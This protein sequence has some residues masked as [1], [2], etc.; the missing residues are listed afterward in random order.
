M[1]PI[2]QLLTYTR[3]L[4][5]LFVIIAGCSIIGAL[6]SF[7]TPF[8]MKLATDWT[9]QVVSGAVPFSAT[10]LLM[11]GG[12]LLAATLLMT[13][14][15]DIN[16]YFG[17]M[18]A[19]RSRQQLSRIYYQHLLTLPQRYYDTASTGKVINRLSRAIADVT[20]FLQFF[21]NNLLQMI[22]TLILTIVIL[23]LYSWP[24]AILF[25]LLIPTNLYVTGKTSGR[26]QKYE[27]EKNGH[28]DYASGRFA[29]V[30]GQMRLVKSFGSQT[31]ELKIFNDEV[32]HMIGITSKQSRWWHGM[33]AIRSTV[34][35]AIFMGIYT[36][37]FYETARGQF[38][39]G[40]MVMLLTLTQQVSFPMRN[41]SYFVDS[42]QRAVANSRDFLEAMNE[43]PESNDSGA[44]LTVHQGRI[45]FENVNFAYE[46]DKKVLQKATFTVEPGT[47]LALV[48]E[49]GG[50]KTT[51]AN[52]LM[53]LYEP[54][55]GTITIDG[56]S[57][58][59]V[60]RAS[61]RHHIA[62]VFQ[63]ASLFS[64]TIRENI[65]YGKPEATDKEIEQ[66]A[67]VANAHEF[68]EKLPHRYQSEIGERG[69]KLSGGQKQRIAIARAV[70]KGA[71]ILVLDEATSALDSR[72]E[73]E[74]QQALERLMHGRT[75]IIIAHR[76]STIASVDRI[77][78]LKNG[79]VDEIGSPLELA[80]SGG[81]YA[82]L[83]DLQMGATDT[84]KKQ[85][86]KF[87][88]AR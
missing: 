75:T 48:G 71:P 69:I 55:S 64:G 7:A 61:L 41:L 20:S 13:A 66:A 52:L 50:G 78:T 12:V 2:R 26:W 62:T 14:A 84:A 87:D 79:H 32:R 43:E 29:E 8:V 22:L 17:D 44:E 11:L 4:Q 34:F 18:L 30:I 46:S 35:G 40:D 49:S 27:K 74:V 68:I 81:I 15:S 5:W 63:E 72:A 9:M 58:A 25:V 51:I 28:F 60:R 3:H 33:N 59:T 67:R 83:L 47:K 85:L 37:L 23:F 10:P 54:S 77:V 76:L 36:I 57:I 19:V 65:S 53:R 24:I 82:Q 6:L 31:R 45:V 42:Y 88:I 38:S 1:H 80:H 70:L 39:I 73:H 86:A 56:V 21:S 16:G